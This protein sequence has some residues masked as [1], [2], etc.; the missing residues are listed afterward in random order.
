MVDI[1]L[2]LGSRTVPSLSKPASHSNSSRLNL[3]SPL[4]HSLTNQL[5]FTSL[6]YPQVKVRVKV[7][8]WPMVSRQSVFMSSPYLQP[9][10]RFWLL[11]DVCGFVDVEC[12]LWWEVRSVVY[13]CCWSLP[14]QSFSG[15]SPTGVMTILYC[16]RFETFPTSRARSLYLY[17]PGTDW[18]SYIPRHW[19]KLN[20]SLT[21]LLIISRHG[22]LRRHRSSVAVYGPLPSKGRCLVICFAVVA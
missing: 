8:L 17:L 1:P 6:T 3:S 4:S 7:M 22:P 13:N 16:L 11:S 14:A 19:V 21:V 15:P 10:T 18:P 2:P 5:L 20:S 9:K 12:L